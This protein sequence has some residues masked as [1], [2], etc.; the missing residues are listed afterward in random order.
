ME[1]LTVA[2]GKVLVLRFLALDQFTIVEVTVLFLYILQVLLGSNVHSKQNKNVD[3]E[4]CGKGTRY[5]G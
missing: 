3:L 1:M 4:H 5:L 2:R